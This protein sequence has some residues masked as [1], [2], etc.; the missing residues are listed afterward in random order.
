MSRRIPVFHA[1]T[2]KYN[3]MTSRIITDVA[4]CN[5]FDPEKYPVPPFP[6]HKTKAL[7]DTG[8]TGSVITTSTVQALNLIPTGTTNVNHAGGSSQ[9]NTYVVNFFLPNKVVLFGI[10]VSECPNIAGNFGAI[11]GM[12]IITQG[13]LSLSWLLQT[14]T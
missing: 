2:I 11:I 3:G 1:L 12:D 8:A 13:D 9:T 14:I 6:L 7:W 5:A 4:I 10:S